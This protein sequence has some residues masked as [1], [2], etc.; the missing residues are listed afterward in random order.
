M[1]YCGEVLSWMAECFRRSTLKCDRDVPKSPRR[2]FSW[3][4]MNSFLY[5]CYSLFKQDWCISQALMQQTHQ[6]KMKKKDKLE[7]DQTRKS[8]SLWNGCIKNILHMLNQ[9]RAELKF[10]NRDEIPPSQNVRMKVCSVWHCVFFSYL[11][12]LVFLMSF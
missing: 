12:L 10:C 6:R 11:F 5:F 7:Q 9:L 8:F 1:K 4:T 3:Y 2:S